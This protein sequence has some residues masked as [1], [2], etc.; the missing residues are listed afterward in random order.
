[1]RQARVAWRWLLAIVVHVVVLVIILQLSDK[2][3]DGTVKALA[4]GMLPQGVRLQDWIGYWD[5]GWKQ[6]IKTFVIF[7]AAISFG[8]YF[9]WNII[10]AIPS[11]VFKGGSMAKKLFIPA[12]L[13]VLLGEVGLGLLY[14]PAMAIDGFTGVVS[15]FVGSTVFYLS[16]VAFIIPFLV[17]LIVCSPYCIASFKNWFRS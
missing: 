7:A 3:Y 11:V 17:S 1:M 8:V 12:V 6:A 16:G 14:H 4:E 13:L 10:F 2:F 5:S 9:L 15:L